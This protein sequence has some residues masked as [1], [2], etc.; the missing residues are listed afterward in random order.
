MG[1]RKILSLRPHHL[2][3]IQNY[4]GKGYD[5][6]FTKNLNRIVR[7]FAGNPEMRIKL[8]EGPD[9]ICK[10]CPNMQE[11]KCTNEEMITRKDTEVTEV[12]GITPGHY[13]RFNEVTATIRKEFL[14]AEVFDKTCKDCS[15]YELCKRTLEGEEGETFLKKGVKK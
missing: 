14:T 9:D 12:C 13:Y 7:I 10:S 1:A 15:W 3:C 4:T 2:L 11:G 6:D 5:D 8:C